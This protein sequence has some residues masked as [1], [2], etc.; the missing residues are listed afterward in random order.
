M[1]ELKQKIHYRCPDI[2]IHHLSGRGIT[3]AVLDTGISS[4][5]DLQ[6][7]ILGWK[8]CVNARQYIYDDNGH[9]THVSGIIS[10]NG[11]CSNGLYSGIAPFSKIVS[12]KVLNAAG[13]GKIQDVITG[14]RF[15]LTMQQKW[16]I[17][18]VNISLGTEDHDDNQGEEKLIWWVEKMWDAGIVVITAAGNMGPD[19]GSITLPGVSKKVITVGACDEIA[20]RNYPNRNFYSGCGPTKE[21]VKKPDICAPGNNIYS[22]NYRYPYKSRKAYVHKS[23]TSMATPAVAGAAAL[24]LEKYP[25]MENVEV[26]MRLWESGDDMNMPESSQGHGRINIEKFLK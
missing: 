12:V 23:G 4:H 1:R 11:F 17:R 24:L 26:K 6:G 7:R 22:C 15:I 13:N 19:Y 18:I 2:L 8:D 16:N 25:Q 9:G 20:V 3:I 14:I 21:C 10:G 5:P